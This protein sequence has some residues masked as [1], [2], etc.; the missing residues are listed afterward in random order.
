M[1]G[2]STWHGAGATV[3]YVEV[4]SW[5]R[6][7]VAAGAPTGPVEGRPAAA[8]AFERDARAASARVLWFAVE[9]PADVG[10]DRPSVVIGAE[11]VWRT[12]RWPEI[13]ASKAS[14]RAQIRRAA[15]KGVVAERWPAKRAS[16]SPELRTVLADW[17]ARRGLPPL[18]FLADPFVLDEPGDR[19]F[20][21]AMRDGAVV[22]Y[23]AFVPGDEAFVE[24]I[25]RARDAP[26]GTSALLLDAAVRDLPPDGTFTLGL[27]PLS[28]HAP[29]SEDAPPLLVR[30]LLAWT[31]AHATR[32]YNF[33]GL[34][35]FKAKFVPDRWRPL[36]LVTDGRPVSM[37]TFHDVAAAFA[38]PRA[39]TRF[40]ARALADAVVEEAGTLARR[41]APALG[42][43]RE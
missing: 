19:Q 41:L 40:V 32:F 33:D 25:I 34:E 39:P 18:A 15:N 8:A 26:N 11:P 31:R 3:D 23:L 28:T 37:W 24:W 35:R 43:G 5:G 42:A 38:A 21:V 30:A 27:V 22:G 13:V 16:A 17:L 6:V 10:P 29:L 9:N 2:L 12:G 7:R 4:R 20:V 36:S 1:P 14:V